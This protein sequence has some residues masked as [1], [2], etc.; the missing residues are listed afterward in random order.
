MA[1]FPGYGPKAYRDKNADKP[2]EDYVSQVNG[3]E[4][5]KTEDPAKLGKNKNLTK[6]ERARQA[7]YYEQ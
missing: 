2:V 3:R 5:T 7:E 4:G 1:R 6:A